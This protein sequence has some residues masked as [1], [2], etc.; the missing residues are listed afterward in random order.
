MSAPDRNEAYQDFYNSNL[1]RGDKGHLWLNA[2]SV[3]SFNAGWDAAMNRADLCDPLQDERV[4]ALEAENARL[5]EALEEISR[6]KKTDEL[7]TELDVEYADFEGGYDAC[8][9]TARAALQE[10]THD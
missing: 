2:T 8:I 7:I 6:Q 4:R 5:R 1:V 10:K 3:S 9:D